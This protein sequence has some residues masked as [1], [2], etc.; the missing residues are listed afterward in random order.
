MTAQRMSC[1]ST[2]ALGANVSPNTSQLNS[3]SVSTS[4]THIVV[5]QQPRAELHVVF[6]VE[7]SDGLKPHPKGREVC[8]LGE[9]LHASDAPELFLRVLCDG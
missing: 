8:C 1:E 7:R 2:Q 6:E 5:G 4:G 3:G 9:L